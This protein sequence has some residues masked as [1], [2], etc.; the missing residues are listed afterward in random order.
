MAFHRESFTDE[1][2]STLTKEII[3]DLIK[4]RNTN[5]NDNGLMNWIYTNN[6][7]HISIPAPTPPP[8]CIMSSTNSTVST[9]IS[10]TVSPPPKL[11]LNAYA[12]NDTTSNHS[13]PDSLSLDIQTIKPAINGWSRYIPNIHSPSSRSKYIP[14]I[15]PPDIYTD[16]LSEIVASSPSP[17]PPTC[18]KSTDLLSPREDTPIQRFCDI[19]SFADTL[20]V[21]TK[22]KKKKQQN[23][24]VSTPRVCNKTTI[25][26]HAIKKSASY[27]SPNVNARGNYDNIRNGISKRKRM[28]TQENNL[29]RKHKKRDKQKKRDGS[30][31]SMPKKKKKSGARLYK[32]YSVRSISVSRPG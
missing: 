23:H 30:C 31:Q 19:P 13:F 25:R 20:R 15:A 2:I 32:Q 6:I 29:K 24:R 11:I 27:T 3:N 22:K 5:P 28:I 1:E 8:T 17:S 16:D 4:N 14:Y 10:S 21:N 18:T 26:P 9:L 12:H 7:K